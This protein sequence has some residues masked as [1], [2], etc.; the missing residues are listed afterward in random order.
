M[1]GTITGALAGAALLFPTAGR[2]QAREETPA[3]SLSF[4]AAVV[5]DYRFRGLS[6]TN[7]KP[8]VQVGAD[9][10][11][12]S[13]WFLGTW[14]TNVADTGSGSNMELDLYGGYGGSLA[15]F[16]YTATLLTYVYPGGTNSDY[17]E[18]QG[19]VAKTMG[20]L[21]TTLTVAAYPKQW[22]TTS[23]LYVSLGN[24]VAIGETPLTFSFSAGR[25]N[26]NYD[27][28]WDWSAGLTYK[29]DAL[30]ISL[31]YIDTNYK[32][33]DEGGKQGRATALLS[34]KASF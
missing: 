7:R 19:T 27:E 30:D 25:E 20:P 24:D 15:G 32:G 26:G 8:A 34:V 18:L 3:A 4:N 13:G 16:D 23:N 31:T 12:S 28:K 6:Y 10:A 21:T 17:Y 29:L 2:S 14:T 9:L 11:F 1:R 22:N 5:S 33:P